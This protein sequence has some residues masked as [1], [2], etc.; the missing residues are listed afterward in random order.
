[1]SNTVSPNAA[2]PGLCSSISLDRGG[3][4]VMD[5]ELGFLAWKSLK[6]ES[7]HNLKFPAT[8]DTVLFLSCRQ[9]MVP[10]VTTKLSLQHLSFFCDNSLSFSI[11]WRHPVMTP[12][13]LQGGG[14]SVG[15][16][17]GSDAYGRWPG[18]GP[19]SG[20]PNKKTHLCDCLTISGRGSGWSLWQPSMPPVKISQPGT[21]C[22]R[23]NIRKDTG[24]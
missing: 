18:R 10:Q 1:M 21:N 3:G 8:D 19:V 17:A 6:N 2:G 22:N 11:L 20:A 24:I 7:C 15:R 23:F 9:P 13:C 16:T 12:S 4:D 14:R 5:D